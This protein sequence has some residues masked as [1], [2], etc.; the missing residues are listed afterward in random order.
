MLLS[1][2]GFPTRGAGAEPQENQQA[3]IEGSGSS[4]QFDKSE[5]GAH[6]ATSPKFKLMTHY[7]IEPTKWAAAASLT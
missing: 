7:Q 2:G 5:V 1:S 4:H 3:E 6:Y